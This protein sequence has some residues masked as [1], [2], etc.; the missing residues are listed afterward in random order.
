MSSTKRSTYLK[1][2]PHFIWQDKKLNAEVLVLGTAHVSAQ[3][4]IDVKELFHLYKP[5]SVAVELCKPRLA[6]LTQPERWKQLDLRQII[7]ERKVW[8]LCSSLILS[9]FQ[10]KLGATQGSPPGMEMK[11]AVELARKNKAA[12]VLADREVRTT[13]ARSWAGIGFFSRLWL[14]SFLFS[15]L[16]VKD[17]ITSEEIEELKKNDMLDNLL[18][19]LPPRYR[20]L[21]TVVLDERDICIAENIRQ[22]ILTERGKNTE[23]IPSKTAKKGAKKISKNPRAK[24]RILAVL[25][26]AHLKGVNKQLKAKKPR[27]ISDLLSMPP[28]RR[29]KN[30]M[31][32]VFLGLVFFLFSALFMKRDWDLAVFQELA[33]AWVLCRSIGAGLGVLIARPSLLSFF[34]SVFLAP[35]SYF[36]GFVGIR[37]WM[38]VALSE[39]RVRKPRV[40]DFENIVKDT[41]SFASFRRSLYHNRVIHLIFLIMMVSLGLTIGNLFFFERVFSGLF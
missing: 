22:H 38:P 33:L 14:S 4:V 36:L 9:S 3:S 19:N 40:A 27:D 1:N 10:K 12:L 30:I 28:R 34:T 8:L 26:A 17:P 2:P 41:E 24:L 16:L 37:L 29:L 11:V 25:G 7:I 15:S 18:R 32:W 5:D 35:I 20:P 13:L 21:R 6:I 39:L 31:T 23:N